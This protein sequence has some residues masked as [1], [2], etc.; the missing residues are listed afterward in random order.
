MKDAEKLH[1]FSHSNCNSGVYLVDKQIPRYSIMIRP[2]NVHGF[3]KPWVFFQPK[4]AILQTDSGVLLPGLRL[5]EE[6][7]DVVLVVL[8]IVASSGDSPVSSNVA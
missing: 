7:V 5:V 6:V 4:K 3:L 2:E 1:M 8:P